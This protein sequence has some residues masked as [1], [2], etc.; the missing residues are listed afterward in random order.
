MRKPADLAR[1][2]ILRKGLLHARFIQ[3]APTK[4]K[5]QQNG[6]LLLRKG[7]NNKGFYYFVHT[8]FP[9]SSPSVLKARVTDTGSMRAQSVMGKE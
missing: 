7:S 9:E 4:I 6:L 2:S 1:I 3:K 8:L 5:N